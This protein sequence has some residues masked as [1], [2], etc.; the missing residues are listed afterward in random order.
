MGVHLELTKIKGEMVDRYDK[1]KI[2]EE[3][4]MEL[5]AFLAFNQGLSVFSVRTRVG[6][7]IRGRERK[8]MSTFRALRPVTLNERWAS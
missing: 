6:T 2:Y 3:T 1:M 7:F 5:V 4:T 8:F